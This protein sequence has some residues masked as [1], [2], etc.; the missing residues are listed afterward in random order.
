LTQNQALS[1]LD[2]LERGVVF[3]SAAQHVLFA[4]RTAEELFR[5][6]DG[7]SLEHGELTASNASL[8]K[9]L[10]TAISEAVAGV[11]NPS[12]TL[13]PLGRPSGLR[14]L[15][16]LVAPLPR[17]QARIGL[18]GAAVVLFITDPERTLVIHVEAI[19]SLFHLTASEANLVAILVEG[20]SLEDAAERL[21]IRRETARK[22]LNTIF[23]KT[24]THRQSELVRLVLISALP[25]MP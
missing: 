13:L 22:R 3:V 4:N 23:Q 24:D 14:A 20:A 17:S 11:L 2:R 19:Q 10:R 6:R 16:V 8:T 25:L 1:A 21:A 18:K 12:N 15:S 5:T 7:L 9:A